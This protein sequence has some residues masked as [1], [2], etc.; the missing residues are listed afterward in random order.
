MPPAS[1]AQRRASLPLCGVR[2]APRLFFEQVPQRVVL[3]GQ[4]GV[5]PLE[6]RMFRLQFLDAL[7]LR[8]AQAA[9]F[10]LPVVV[11]RLADAVL[12]AEVADLHARI[13]LFEDRDNLGLGE[14]A[15]LHV[16]WGNPAT[17]LLYF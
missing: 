14:S 17:L 2:L 8:D 7:E 11:G 1:S 15:F 13:G 16:G 4:V 6:L 10:A 9:V 5:H 3:H 12:A